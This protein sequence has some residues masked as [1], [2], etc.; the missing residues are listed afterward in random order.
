MPTKRFDGVASL[1]RWIKE[2][3]SSFMSGPIE[4]HGE[5]RNARINRRGVL[6]L[7]LVETVSTFGGSYSYQIPCQLNDPSGVLSLLKV[8]SPTEMES[9]DYLIVGTLQFRVTQ[10]RYV[11]EVIAIEPYGKGAIEKRRKRILETL[12][13]EGLFPVEK[14]TSISE[15]GEPLTKMAVVASPG[16][17]GLVDLLANLRISRLIPDFELFPVAVEGPTAPASI[18]NAIEQVNTTDAQII[19]IVRGGGAQSGLL[20]LDDERLARGIIKSEIPVVVGI[21][22]TEDVTLLDYVAR[23][24]LETP[25]AVGREIA[26]V[27]DA[28]VEGLESIHDDFRFSFSE[29]ATAAGRKVSETERAVR[30][31]GL[32]RVAASN[33]KNIAVLA[34][35]LRSFA[36]SHTLEGSGFRRAEREFY[37]TGEHY[38]RN[39][40]EKLFGNAEGLH[41]TVTHRA[42]IARSRLAKSLAVV[43]SMNPIRSLFRGGAIVTDENGNPI[44]SIETVEIGDELSIRVEDGTISSEVLSKTRR[45]M[46]K[47]VRTG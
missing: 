2:V 4:F 11:V 30:S 13:K 33:L 10:N 31:Y 29:L 42:E 38:L 15:L 35:T 1:M 16:T 34:R 17:R 12:E 22:H 21:G 43:R 14:M 9:E 36:D 45:S 20:Y 26:S 18:A 44:T 47:S 27:N 23:L 41:E 25:T 37:K 7:E 8:G 3:S 5:V 28:Y 40:A 46:P 19:V 32:L 24:S 6:D 39:A